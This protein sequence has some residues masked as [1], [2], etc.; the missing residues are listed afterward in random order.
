MMVFEGV[1]GALASVGIFELYLPFLLLFSIFFA[2]LE[3]TK[4]FA[5][6]KDKLNTKVD[7][8]LAFIISLYIIAFSPIAGVIGLWFGTL[9]AAVGATLVALIIFFLVVGLMVSPWWGDVLESKSW[10][11]LIPIG[12]IIAFLIVL[13]STFGGVLGGTGGTISIPG[14]TSQDIVFLTL[15]VITI[16][17][18]YWMIRAPGKNKEG[19]WFLKPD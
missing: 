9:F 10:K 13:G 2:I 3:K 14:L 11:W 1:I 4:I 17:I 16:L 15:V 8:I 5:F 7:V 18:I 12:V 6:D 19:K